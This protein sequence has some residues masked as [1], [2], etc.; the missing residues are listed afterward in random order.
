MGAGF[1]AEVED[2]EAAADKALRPLSEE[3]RVARRQI[4]STGEFDGAFSAGPDS[5]FEPQLHVWE[6][7]RGFLERVLDD[8]AETLELAAR[9]LREIA[10]RYR[11]AEEGSEQAMQNIAREGLS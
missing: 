2:L 6:E 8:N 5:I 11:A 3:L 4:T 9:A 10:G 1:K 7:T